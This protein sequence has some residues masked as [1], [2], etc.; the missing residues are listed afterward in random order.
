MSARS[1]LRS[2]ILYWLAGYALLLAAGVSLHGFMVNEYAER[3]LWDSLVKTEFERYQQRLAADPGYHWIDSDSMKLYVEGGASSLPQAFDGLPEGIHDELLMDNGSE[4]LVLIRNVDG[5]RHAL[6]LDI[7]EMEHEEDRLTLF[8]LGSAVA[9]VTLTGMLMA[10]GLGRAL[11]PLT[12]MAVAIGKLSPDHSGQRIAIDARASS[13]LEVIATALNDYLQRNERFVERE[14]ALVNTTSH[15]LRTPIAVIDGAAEIGLQSPD[16]P[17]ATRL[18]LLRIQ[19][20]TRDMEQLVALLLALAKDPSRLAQASQP[21]ALDALLPDIVE[22]HRY[23]TEG[24]S[25]SLQVDAPGACDIV[26]PPGIVR[27]A[28][29]NLLRNAI[30]HSDNGI[31]HIELQADSTVVI[32]D[33]GHGM[34]PEQISAVYSQLARGTPASGDGIGLDLIA[35]LCAHLGWTLDFQSD[36]GGTTATL[37]LRALSDGRARA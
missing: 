4:V 27:A 3:L 35:R 2:S 16:I 9:L 21:I 10:L 19:R 6:S 8:I 34:A 14:L 30:E 13:E 12:D 17:D 7:T 1:S 31:I 37:G 29:G 11:R 32:R 23:L 33:P 36:E 22:D 20:T 25:L 26:A 18:Q 24:K 28:I 15:E 5:V